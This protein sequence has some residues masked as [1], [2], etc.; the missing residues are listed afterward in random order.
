MESGEYADFLPS[1]GGGSLWGRSLKTEHVF[2]VGA[3]S[4]PPPMYPRPPGRRKGSVLQGLPDSDL[5]ALGSL[6]SSGLGLTSPERSLSPVPR[7]VAGGAGERGRPPA[8]APGGQTRETSAWKL[9]ERPAPGLTRVSM[10]TCVLH[11]APLLPADGCWYLGSQPKT[12]CRCQRRHFRRSSAC[13]WEKGE[14]SGPPQ[15]SLLPC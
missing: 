12:P 2:Q 11:V 8:W 6:L 10:E 14:W 3:S 4:V 15:G 5:G 1:I 9:E 7:G 13:T